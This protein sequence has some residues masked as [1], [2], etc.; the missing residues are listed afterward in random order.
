MSS[1]QIALLLALLALPV[2]WWIRRRSARAREDGADA[3]RIDTLIGW[4]PEATRVLSH[5]ERLAF[6]T[7]VQALPDF[8][9]LAQVPLSR[10]LNVPKRHSYADW[11][12]RLG[13]QCAD[14]IVCDMHAQVLA[15]VELQ[16]LGGPSSERARQRLERM[17]RS[18]KAAKVPLH[19]WTEGLL[20]SAEMAREAIVPR[21][22]AVPATPPS[23]ESPN[24]PAAAAASR[25]RAPALNPFDDTSRDSAHDEHIELLEPPPSTWFDD[26]DSGPVPLRTPP[27]VKPAAPARTRGR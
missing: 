5:A 22:V 21:P 4:P 7:L 13:N 10:F 1:L 12:R 19:V 17:A 8:M 26:L 9:I 11:L 27:G 16:A 3:D 24:V 20:P 25:P 6:A 18:L 2:L 14:F 15:V 23:A